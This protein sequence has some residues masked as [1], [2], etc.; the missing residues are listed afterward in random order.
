LFA[1]QTQKYYFDLY[2][3]DYEYLYVEGDSVDTYRLTKQRIDYKYADY[4]SLIQICSN[5]KMNR[6]GDMDTSLSVS[7]YAR[8]KGNSLLKTLKLN[9]ENFF[10]NY[11][12]T[13]TQHNL[14]TT[15]KEY[16]QPLSGKGYTKGFLSSNMRASNDYK[17]R[18]AVA[19]LVNKFFNPHIKNFFVKNGVEVDE[20][21]FALSEMIQFIFRSAIRENREIK[22]YIPSSRMRSILRRWASE[23]GR[24]RLNI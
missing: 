7:W 9:A 13:K 5:E 20:D 14:W 24:T 18:T 6:I 8:N 12:K 3:V 19:Y 21:A 17:D 2:G 4:N 15:F 10:K 16:Q 11:T 22:L 1:A 23:V